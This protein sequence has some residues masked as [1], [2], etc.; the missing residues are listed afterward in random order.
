VFSWSA[1]EKGDSLKCSSYKFFWLGTIGCGAYSIGRGC[2]CG[3]A[4]GA[5]GGTS[6]ELL[7]SFC[8]AGKG[9]ISGGGTAAAAAADT[10]VG[11]VTAGVTSVSIGVVIARVVFYE[12]V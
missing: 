4:T 10:G 11:A 2:G 9:M 7:I 8:L 5:K 3:A 1:L 6:V 12:A